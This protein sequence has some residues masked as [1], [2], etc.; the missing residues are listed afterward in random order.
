[1][2]I[3]KLMT[4][5]VKACAPDEHL[6]AAAKIMWDADCGI[7]P[8]VDHAGQVVGVVT[9]R[10][11]CI[12]CWTRD[13]KP[14]DLRVGDTMTTDVKTCKPEETIAAAEKLMEKHQVRRLP[15]TDAKNKLVGIISMNDISREAERERGQGTKRLDIRSDEVVEALAAICRPRAAG[16][17]EQAS[18]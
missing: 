7:V 17:R 5:N 9:D 13:A 12:A 15:V 3:E 10:D 4:S 2:K 14:S 6:S 11:I 8:V 1:M 16:S 18:R